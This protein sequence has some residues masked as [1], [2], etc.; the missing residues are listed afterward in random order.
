MSNGR[1]SIASGDFALKYLH[2]E[3]KAAEVEVID[4]R[5]PVEWELVHLEGCK[6]IPLGSLP[7]RFEEID[8]DK[9]VYLLCAHGVRSLQATQ[10]LLRQGYQDVVNVE[11][12]LA[13]VLLYIDWE[14]E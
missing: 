3:L 5:E 10:F 12:G 9:T 8:A 6:H 13:E 2:D 14:E 4:V 11:G 7:E 1:H